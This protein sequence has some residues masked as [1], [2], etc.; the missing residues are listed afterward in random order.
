MSHG[1]CITFP[2]F[3]VLVEVM[4]EKCDAFNDE[5]YLLCKFTGITVLGMSTVVQLMKTM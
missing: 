5:I 4:E 1:K 3:S 2:T